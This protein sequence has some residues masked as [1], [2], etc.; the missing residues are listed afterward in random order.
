MDNEILNDALWVA[1]KSWLPCEDPSSGGRHPHYDNRQILAGVLFILVRGLAWEA[2]PP[3][4]GWGSGM[5]CWRHWRAWQQSGAWVPMQQILESHGVV[6]APRPLPGRRRRDLYKDSPEPQ[7][8]QGAGSLRAPEEPES[9][10]SSP[11]AA[12]F[13]SWLKYQRRQR[14]LTQRT[15]AQQVNCA[16]VTIQSIE[17]GYRKPSVQLACSLAAALEVPPAQ[18]PMFVAWAR[19]TTERREIAGE[20]PSLVRVPELREHV[21]HTSC[22]EPASDP[23]IEEYWTMDLPTEQIDL[24]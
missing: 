8:R 23:R 4:N 2:L 22:G 11:S 5:T 19:G 17:A 15:L 21:S 13:S 3:E 14:H 1:I 18:Q 16:T 20:L 12:M 9:V 24:L 10:P 6:F 7:H